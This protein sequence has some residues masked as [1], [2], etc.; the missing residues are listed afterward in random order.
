MPPLDASGVDESREQF[1][2][3]VEEFDVMPAMAKLGGDDA[4]PFEPKFAS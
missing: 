2:W 4:P 3:F 1:D